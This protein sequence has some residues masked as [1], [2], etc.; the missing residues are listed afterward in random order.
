MLNF[1]PDDPITGP[2]PNI[3]V[4]AGYLAEDWLKENADHIK[5][6]AEAEE[7]LE[8]ID[9]SISRADFSGDDEGELMQRSWAFIG[10][11]ILRD[12]QRL[13]ISRSRQDVVYIN[14]ALI[15]LTLIHRRQTLE[16]NGVKVCNQD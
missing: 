7:L 4:M 15:S 3:G 11:G 14:L 12:I 1:F 5:L 2:L 9:L 6:T 16:R 8:A 10:P 13:K